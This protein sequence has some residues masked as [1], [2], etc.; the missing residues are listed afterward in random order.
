M[1]RF[2]LWTWPLGSKIHDGSMFPMG[3]LKLGA[4]T[5][6]IKL[7]VLLKVTNTNVVFPTVTPLMW[8]IIRLCATIHSNMVVDTYIGPLSFIPWV[9]IFPPSLRP[10]S[11]KTVTWWGLFKHWKYWC[12][13]LWQTKHK[14]FRLWFSCS[15]SLSLNGAF[16]IGHTPG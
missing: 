2:M 5:L 7:W 13:N 8:I 9:S 11:P 15:F 12:P 6:D 4:K 1:K 3:W 10:F 16:N 14:P